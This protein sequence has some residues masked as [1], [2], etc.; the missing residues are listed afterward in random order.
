MEKSRNIAQNRP[1]KVEDRL[2]ADWKNHK[3]VLEKDQKELEKVQRIPQISPFAAQLQ[4]ERP[5][6]ER[7]LLYNNIYN[8]R[9]KKAIK[10]VPG[11]SHVPQINSY[12][13]NVSRTDLSSPRSPQPL[14][15]PY[16][17]K[18][19][20]NKNSLKIAEKLGPFG[21]RSS[22]HSKSASNESFSF[23][24]EINKNSSMASRRSS[25][26]RWKKLYGL[27]IERRERL[28]LLR[29]ALAENDVDYECTFQPKTLRKNGGLTNT[30]TVQR[31]NDWEKRRQSKIDGMRN[32]SSD[33][34][35]DECTFKPMLYGNVVGESMMSDFYE[36]LKKKKK[37]YVDIHRNKFVPDAIEWRCDKVAPLFISDINSNEYDEAIK[38]LH[39]LLHVGLK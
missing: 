29:Q 4:S 21:N 28:E 19:E 31:L 24:P 17:F 39:D 13:I 22:L 5:V 14:S 2:I 18:P 11:H 10:Q 23:K 30:D 33:K 32:S 36:E 3:L 15:N 34:N 27:N 1:G 26:P 9:K 7:L 6:V 12:S 37:N 25:S 8:E 38:E 35:L 20:L 16:S